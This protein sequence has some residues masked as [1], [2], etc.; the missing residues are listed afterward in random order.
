MNPNWAYSKWVAVVALCAVAG[1]AMAQGRGGPRMS[2]DD[3]QK[4]WELEAKTVVN[5]LDLA[6]DAQAKVVE[7]FK[8]ARKEQNAAMREAFSGGG[9]DPMAR[10]QTMRDVGEKHVANLRTALTETIGEDDGAK[11]AEKL[12]A[13]DRQ[14]DAMALV[15]TTLGLEETK[16]AD[17]MGLVG[18]YA[19]GLGKAREEA[20]ASMSMD[21]MRT[22]RRDLK[23][24]L[25][26]GMAKV[27]SEDQ[28]ATWKEKTQFRGRRGGRGGGPGRGGGTSEN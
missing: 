1:T 12:A 28:L 19:A 10:F 18:T 16:L 11:A 24:A 26:D 8:T 14:S 23:T 2:P 4:V 17:G 3:A 15:L 27:L 22:A 9:G 25:D 21:S 13:F 5:S 6:E 20:F 7:A